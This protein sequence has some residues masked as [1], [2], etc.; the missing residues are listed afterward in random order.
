MSRPVD[1]SKYALIYGGAQKNVGPAGVTFVIVRKDILG[2]VE[3]H[4]P[5]MLDYQTHI[6]GGSMFNTLPSIPFTL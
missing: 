5:S 4:I 1:I 6:K 3:R 2:K